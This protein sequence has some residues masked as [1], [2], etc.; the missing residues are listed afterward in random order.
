MS[1]T[2][3]RLLGQIMELSELKSVYAHE[4]PFVTVYLEGRSPGED[5]A[6]QVRLRWRDLR[7]RLEARDAE[8]SAL[9]AVE[10][11]LDEGRFGE[12]QTN[13]RVLVATA[14]GVVLDEP[15]DAALGA[16]DAAFSGVLPELGPHVREASEAV[17]VLL[18]IAGQ[19]DAELRRLV[20]AA[21]HAPDETARE[22][23]RGDAVERPH[24]IRE[25][26]L[27]HRRI[28]RRADEAVRQNAKEISA[29]V[30]TAVARFRPDVVVLAGE[31]QGRTAVREQLPALHP[32]LEETDRGGREDD[33]AEEA[34]RD[35][36]LR[37]A[38]RF[39]DRA[40]E[41]QASRLYEADAK[42]LATRGDPQVM[43]AAESGAV[44]TLLI[45]RG[46]SVAREALLLKTGAQTGAGVAVVP[47]GTDLP[48]GIGAVLRFP[49]EG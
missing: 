6:K 1:R 37:I 27:A 29:A 49:P 28:Q 4:G 44:D 43:K 19:E 39:T 15:W 46:R 40:A 20:V 9:D 24:H 41:D 31:V 3:E 32:L 14:G 36:V 13:G 47:R 30:D 45:E 2:T 42:G 33:R 22:E 21:D 26:A 7:E 8:G 38:A 25:G 5:A 23:V 10:E 34:L 16:G 18:V 35:E 11:A 12:E 17:R 48:D